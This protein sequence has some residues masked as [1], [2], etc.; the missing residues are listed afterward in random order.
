MN[1]KKIMI[2]AVIGLFA[3]ISVQAQEIPERKHDSYKPHSKERGHNKKEMADLNLSEEQKTK[4]KELNKEHR[5]QMEDLK[6]QDNITVK[7]SRERMEKIRKEHQAKMQSLLTTEQ[8]AKIE[9]NKLEQRE[10]RVEM[11]TKRAE[12]MKTELGLTDEQSAK[13]LQNRKDAGEKMKAIR[14]DKSLTEEQKKEKIKE[15]YKQQKETLKSVL[16][17]EQMKKLKESDQK[18]K[19]GHD[20]NKEKT[21]MKET[22]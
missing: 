7:E 13:M 15:L 21:E 4:F 14:E 3:A 18:R 19:E 2:T 10:K 11:G 20:R 17:E 22:K 1:M 5:Q 16:T 9:K 6:K 8:K 12:R